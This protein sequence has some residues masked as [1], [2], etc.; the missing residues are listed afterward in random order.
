MKR[1]SIAAPGKPREGREV[2]MHAGN[3]H[4]V[5]ADPIEHALA[6]GRGHGQIGIE[7]HAGFGKRG[8]HFGYM[9]R[10]AQIIN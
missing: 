1:V 9:H 6:R 7:G 2:Q 4:A 10:V 8:L 3:Q 5:G